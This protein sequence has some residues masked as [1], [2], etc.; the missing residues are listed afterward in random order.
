[1][2]CF[3]QAGTGGSIY[4]DHF[5]EE[6]LSGDKE[7]IEYV[8]DSWITLLLERKKTFSYPSNIKTKYEHQSFLKLLREIEDK[9]DISTLIEISNIYFAS[10]KKRYERILRYNPYG[11]FS[12]SFISD[13]YMFLKYLTEDGGRIS[14]L[15]KDW[16]ISLVFLSL[17]GFSADDGKSEYIFSLKKIQEMYKILFYS[18]NVF[19]PV[20]HEALKDR[21]F[22]QTSEASETFMEARKLQQELDK[23]KHIYLNII[24]PSFM[25]LSWV[26]YDLQHFNHP[27]VLFDYGQIVHT[28][29]GKERGL[30]YIMLSARE[31]YLPAVRYLGKYYLDQ[32]PYK[33]DMGEHLMTQYLRYSGNNWVEKINITH[34]LFLVN[35]IKGDSLNDSFQNGISSLKRSCKAIFSR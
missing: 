17:A 34:Q 22:A 28:A 29:Y 24:I 2:H 11:Y 30:S 20:F 32:I 35:L 21:F 25:R 14:S 15:V 26:Q 27:A 7:K 13:R 12:F 3:S 23:V 10:A 9:K 1:M 8:I 33:Q 5:T 4:S 18:L 16:Y 6:I 31:N 19:T